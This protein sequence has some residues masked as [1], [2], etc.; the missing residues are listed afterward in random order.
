LVGGE[1]TRS[2]GAAR[3]SV[4]AMSLIRTKIRFAEAVYPALD[5]SR[6]ERLLVECGDEGGE[7]FAVQIERLTL[8]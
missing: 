5:L 7:P 3:R 4:F 8:I 2:A 1:R 6:P